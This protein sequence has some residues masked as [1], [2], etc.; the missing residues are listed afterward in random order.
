MHVEAHSKSKDTINQVIEKAHNE[1]KDCP[2]C[3]DILIIFQN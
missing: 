1:D 2:I 3:T